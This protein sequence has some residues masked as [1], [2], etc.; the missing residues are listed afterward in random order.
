[1][2]KLSQTK[3]CVLDQF[4]SRT[5]DWTF[6]AFEQALK[7][8]TGNSYGNYQTAK[9]TINSAAKEGLW[10]KTV[11]RYVLTNFAALGSSPAE[12]TSICTQYL[13]SMDKAEKQ[14]WGIK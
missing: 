7:K 1:M 13:T 6:G 5:D 8:A 2:S 12:L 4:E 11:K 3:R 10:P 14:R 9:L